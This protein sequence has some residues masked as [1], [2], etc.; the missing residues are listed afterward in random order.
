AP[1]NPITGPKAFNSG[2]PLDNN[3]FLYT[4]DEAG[5]YTVASQGAPGYS[6]VVHIRD[7]IVQTA[8]PYNISEKKG[9]TVER[10]YRVDLAC[11]T[12]G[13]EIYYTT[14][15]SMPGLHHYATKHYKK[16]RGILLKEPGLC[17]VR[18]MASKPEQVCSHVF[19]SR[20]YWVLS[21][22]KNKD[23][24]M[25]EAPSSL[26]V[27][28]KQQG[29]SSWD[30]W[31]CRP[32]IKGCFTGPG[33]VNIFWDLPQ[34][35]SAREQIKGYQLLL[36]GVSY[37]S[38][39]PLNNNSLNIQGLAGGRNYRIVVVVHP[40]D[41]QNVEIESNSLNLQCPIETEGGGPLISLVKSDKP[42]SLSIVWMS[43]DTMD[44]SVE[45]Y[46]IYLND[47]QCGPK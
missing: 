26:P 44:T 10:Y 3:C 18:A 29:L 39:F 19:T 16:D 5:D 1:L 13:A 20:C 2:K 14:D 4:F 27:E 22:D 7:E 34:S 25:D 40:K 37:C 38:M 9:G 28:S 21:G 11:K 36:N 33:S 24:S 45:S 47:Q 30:W 12:E 46:V 41:P 35:E 23:D 17:F 15:G 8:E 42:D 43:V 6:C 32:H 31:N